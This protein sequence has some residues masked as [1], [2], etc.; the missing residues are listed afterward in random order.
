MKIDVA[1]DAKVITPTK[2]KALMNACLRWVM[3]DHKNKTIPKHF[4]LGANTRYQYKP[5]SRGYSIKKKRMVHHLI[6]LV[7]KGWLRATIIQTSKVT[8]TYKQ[9]RMYARGYFPMK[10]E[11]REQIEKVLPSEIADMAAS[12]A[13]R[14]GILVQAENWG[15]KRARRK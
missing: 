15:R 10:D 5:I 3:T 1:F 6:P 4:A 14:Y 9:A 11:F 8:A 7:L 2:H 13:K 12:I